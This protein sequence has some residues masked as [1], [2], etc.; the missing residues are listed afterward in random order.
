[1]EITYEITL[2]DAL[3]L[4]LYHNANSSQARRTL[5]LFRTVAILVFAALMALALLSP[6]QAGL[7]AADRFVA[8][9]PVL[10]VGVAVVSFFPAIQRW[11]VKRGVS[12]A[13]FRRQ[14][15]GLSHQFVLSLGPDGLVH[16]SGA[17]E[18]VTP[19][20]EVREI[21]VEPDHCFFFMDAATALIVPARAF[22]GNDAWAHFTDAARRFVGDARS[23]S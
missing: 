5:I 7:S 22:P 1:M 12:N 20:E 10:L 11:A 17:A 13:F 9:L 16:S 21:V 3:A 2:E 14:R 18:R 6:A 8:L 23:G 19:W 15:G 4:G